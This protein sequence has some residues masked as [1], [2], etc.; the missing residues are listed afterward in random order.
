MGVEDHLLRLARIGTH[1]HHPARAKPSVRDLHRRR[2][3]GDQDNLVAPV[4]LVGLARRK[5]QR[6]EGF[7]LCGAALA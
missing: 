7:R 5:G 6:H 2:D 1:E 4:E 3:A